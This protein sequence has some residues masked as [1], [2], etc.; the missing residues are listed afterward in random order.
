[1]FDQITHY[2]SVA[3]GRHA[4]LV[5]GAGLTMWAAVNDLRCFRIPNRIPVALVVTGTVWVLLS[6]SD[7][8]HHLAAAV[9]ML[10]IGFGLY[11]ARLFGAG[12]AKLMS[13]LALWLGPVMSV[14]FFFQTAIFGAILGLFWLRTRRVR[15]V[16][17]GL[18]FDIAPEPPRYIP[19][20]VAIAMAGLVG[21]I[22]LWPALSV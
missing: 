3:D 2:I 22:R 6:G 7:T 11:A 5:V 9:G 19:Y 4:I 8:L 1:M 17:V 12:D 14:G 21:F 10:A 18:G 13:A 15:T 16:L 20:G